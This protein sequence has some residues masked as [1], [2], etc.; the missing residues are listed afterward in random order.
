MM[1]RKLRNGKKLQIM[2][3]WEGGIKYKDIG[4]ASNVLCSTNFYWFDILEGLWKYWEDE[5]E[6]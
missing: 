1:Y 2:E 5:K 6:Q 4:K 3:M